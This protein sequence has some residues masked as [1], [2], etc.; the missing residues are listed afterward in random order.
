MKYKVYA[1]YYEIYVTESELD[2]P[3][4]L[5]YEFD[6]PDEVLGYLAEMDDTI[7]VEDSLGWEDYGYQQVI[8]NNGKPDLIDDTDK[9]TCERWEN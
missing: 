2:K 7:L 3:Y 9:R 4:E 8:V 6:D 5:Q 1:G